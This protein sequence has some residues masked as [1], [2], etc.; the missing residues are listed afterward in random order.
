MCGKSNFDKPLNIHIEEQR[1]EFEIY[2]EAQIPKP[3]EIQA[4]FAIKPQKKFKSRGICNIPTELIT[5]EPSTTQRTT[6][7]GKCYVE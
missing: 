3:G 7:I 2:T 1:Q 5:T 6:Q 4:E